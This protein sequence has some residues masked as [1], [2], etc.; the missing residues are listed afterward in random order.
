MQPTTA[1]PPTVRVGVTLAATVLV[2]ALVAVAAAPSPVAGAPAVGAASSGAGPSVAAGAQATG[3][4]SCTTID[5]PGR[6]V[7]T[8]DV[9]A[10]GGGDCI[11]VT[12]SDVTVDG[13]GHTVS[14]DGDHGIFVDG[15]A[16]GTV[17]NV[18]VTRVKTVGWSIGVFLLDATRSRVT[19]VVAVDA[20]EGIALGRSSNN[21]LAND[22]LVGN[23]LGFALGGDSR[24]NVLRD[25]VATENKF[26]I[27]FERGS[28]GNLVVDNA[29]WNNTRWDHYSTLDA[30]DN[31]TRNLTL[32][33]ATVGLE[34]RD[35]A[36]RAIDAAP[37]GPSGQRSLGAYTRVVHTR[38]EAPISLTMHYGE[39]V[40]EGTAPTLWRRSEGDWMQVAGADV[41]A[42][43]RTVSATDVGEGTFGLFVAAGDGGGP[44]TVAPASLPSANTTLEPATVSV[45]TATATTA[46]T[47]TATA[48]TTPPPDPASEATRTGAGTGTTPEATTATAAGTA[49]GPA[50]T[51]TVDASGTTD[52]P[53]ATEVPATTTSSDDGPGFGP[54]IAALAGLAAALLAVRRR[55]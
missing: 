51:G 49:T 48:A 22:T 43:N 38:G 40:A 15:S 18:T 36:V 27:H 6:Y 55:R 34:S 1:R 10:S 25:N 50:T 23:A 13:A 19:D 24:N 46:A 53:P 8:A 45:A 44:A 30:G 52:A 17:S 41:D 12:A 4:D 31:P 3:I 28:D 21:L 14:G 5:T 11:V 9:S 47:P 33:S 7:L 39:S 54:A 29:A 42:A 32:T 26:G 20:T 2:L 16:T 35:V 37:P